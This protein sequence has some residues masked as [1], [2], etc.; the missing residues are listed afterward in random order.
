MNIGYWSWLGTIY[1]LILTWQDYK[2]NK[3]VDDRRNWLMM[4][5]SIS[6]ISHTYT[7]IWY[8]LA[9]A[10]ILALLYV[11]LRKIKTL[12][13][14]DSNTYTW[15][16]LGFGLINPYYLAL[17][18]AIFIVNTIL[19]SLLKKLFKI[20]EATQFYGVLLTSFVLALFFFGLY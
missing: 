2:N 5:L 13:E 14:A 7:T 20:K 3:M 16:F 4:G 18:T 12:G 19:F 15:I 6:L 9:L 17:F 8:K 10:I 1:L 11:F